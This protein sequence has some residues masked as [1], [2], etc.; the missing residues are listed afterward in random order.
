MGWEC[1]EGRESSGCHHSGHRETG[2][3][4]GKDFAIIP[5]LPPDPSSLEG[6]CLSLSLGAAGINGIADQSISTAQAWARVLQ[7][8][9]NQWIRMSWF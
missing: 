2:T 1:C 6:M 5:Y 9:I 7:V 3:G 4:V 8:I